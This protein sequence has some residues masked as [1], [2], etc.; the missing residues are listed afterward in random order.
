MGDFNWDVFISHASEDKET[1]ARPL[2]AA[3]E[4]RGVR[5]WLDENMVRVGQ[6]LMAAI[7]KGLGESRL[8][9][10]ILSERFFAK[11]WTRHKLDAL[12]A[13]EEALGQVLIPVWH[14]VDSHTI[15]AH[16][17]QL[18][19]RIGVSTELGAEH[20]ATQVLR[21]LMDLS[22]WR[23]LAALGW[24]CF[25][26]LNPPSA[27][28]PEA[29]WTETNRRARELAL[30]APD[31]RLPSDPV[32]AVDTLGSRIR[33]RRGVVGMGSFMLGAIGPAMMLHIKTE[34]Y[35]RD[36]GRWYQDRHGRPL[37]NVRL[38]EIERIAST[39]QLDEI[40]AAVLRLA[41]T[42]EVR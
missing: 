18:A 28:V 9:V 16:S 19:K 4:Q 40:H 31:E 34:Q 17:P 22:P 32:A 37:G 5:V 11:Q 1:A 27:G 42:G 15:E 24:C 14:G 36:L 20:V 25:S 33:T 38:R 6:P 7:D 39:G 13:R 29:V 26:L 21:V 23:P 41:E 8:G 2:T 12:A 30:A 35:R 3:L 10:V